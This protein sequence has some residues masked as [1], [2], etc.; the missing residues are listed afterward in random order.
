MN[1]KNYILNWFLHESE[2]GTLLTVAGSGDKQ[3]AIKV[4][5]ETGQRLGYYDGAFVNEIPG[6]TYRYL[7]SGPATAATAATVVLPPFRGARIRPGTV[8]RRPGRACTCH[9]HSAM[10]RCDTATGAARRAARL[11]REV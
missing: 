5:T 11:R 8:L 2:A 4:E 6:A 1:K 3:M 9:A 10:Q 7:I